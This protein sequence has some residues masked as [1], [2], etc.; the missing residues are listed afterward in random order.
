MKLTLILVLTLSVSSLFAAPICKQSN[1]W[2]C[3]I[4]SKYD[5]N[6]SSILKKDQIEPLY[7]NVFQTK[8]EERI[9]A[10]FDF[11]VNFLKRFAKP[12]FYY[13]VKTGKILNPKTF[14]S[15]WDFTKFLLRNARARDI[16]MDYGDF[17]SAINTFQVS[18]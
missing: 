4:F 9:A 10:E 6:N 11:N 2:K 13:H 12:I 15:I 8:V 7:T 14:D 18:E 5:A 17:A 1:Q 16:E 3:D